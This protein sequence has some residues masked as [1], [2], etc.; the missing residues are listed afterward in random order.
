MKIA[1]QIAIVLI[2]LIVVPLVLMLDGHSEWAARW[3]A[4]LYGVGWLAMLWKYF[5]YI[6]AGGWVK[7]RGYYWFKRK[8]FTTSVSEV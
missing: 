4:Y 3:V 7:H 5:F 8:G 1:L 2:L 6:S